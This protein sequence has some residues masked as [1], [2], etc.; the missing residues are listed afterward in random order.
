MPMTEL[1]TVVEHYRKQ[2]VKLQ[3]S[4]DI[5]EAHGSADKIL[6]SLLVS[7]GYEDIVKEYDKIGK[8][9]A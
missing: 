4:Q 7:L 2:L 5:E 3:K 6:C 9:Y 1:E 8:W